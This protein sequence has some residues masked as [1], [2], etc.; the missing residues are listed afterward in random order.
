MKVCGEDCKTE[1]QKQYSK[2]HRENVE[3][4]PCITAFENNRIAYDN[5]RK[6]FNKFDFPQE[7]IDSYEA[8]KDKFLSVGKIKKEQRVKGLISDDSFMKWVKGEAAKR[9]KLEDEVLGK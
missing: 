2:K 1:R 9:V 4:D 3:Q 6:K 7:F 8:V 5:F